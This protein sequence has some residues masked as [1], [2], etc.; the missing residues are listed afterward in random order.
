MTV[1]HSIAG[2]Q[3]RV[4]TYI[5]LPRIASIFGGPSGNRRAS[6]ARDRDRGAD[7]TVAHHT[8]AAPSYI[9]V[10]STGQKPP[11]AAFSSTTNF[12]RKPSYRCYITRAIGITGGQSAN[13]QVMIYAHRCPKRTN[14]SCG[15]KISRSSPNS[16]IL[17]QSSPTSIFCGLVL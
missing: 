6:P 13:F 2:A 15:T 16:A 9:A 17:L 14:Q 3:S 1:I 11:L 8:S 7:V 10:R 12:R 5:S 4:A